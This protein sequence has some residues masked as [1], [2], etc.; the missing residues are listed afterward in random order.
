MRH[1]VDPAAFLR[2]A[3]LPFASAAYLP[4]VSSRDMSALLDLCTA[5]RIGTVFLCSAQSGAELQHLDILLQVSEARAAMTV[6]VTRIVAMAGDN[7]H[8][9]LAAASFSGKSQ[10][11]VGL[12]WDAAAL[13]A[14]MGKAGRIGSDVATHA[15]ATLLLAAA[16]AG[17]TAI[18]TSETEEDAEDFRTSCLHAHAQGFGGKMTRKPSQVPIIRSVFP[19]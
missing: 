9:L 11:L 18:D 6:G 1:G 8:G 7:P 12:G 5:A 4:P 17:V 19:A 15:R 16:A 3:S 13:A 14:A 10:R 2:A